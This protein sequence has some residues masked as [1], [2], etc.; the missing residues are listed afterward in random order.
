MKSKERLTSWA[1]LQ[2]KF[3]P[4]LQLEV[5]VVPLGAAAT[6]AARAAMGRTE[7]NRMN[8]FRGRV[9]ELSCEGD[10]MLFC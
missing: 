9:G 7:E 4:L 2:Q 1:L 6:T 3:E 10:E 8:I 5:V